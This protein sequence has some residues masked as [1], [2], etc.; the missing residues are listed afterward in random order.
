MR[1]ASITGIRQNAN[2]TPY[3]VSKAAVIHLTKQ[4]AL[5]LAENDIRVNAIAPGYFES[6]L[7]RDFFETDRGQALIGR[8]PQNRLGDYDSLGSAVLLLCSDS[9][10]YMTGAV[11]TV[12]GGHTLNSL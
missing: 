2:I 8:I 4:M 10:S 7:T 5:E 11:L 3:A 12:D 1:L 6:D 9:S